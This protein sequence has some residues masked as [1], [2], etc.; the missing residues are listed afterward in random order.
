MRLHSDSAS[1]GLLERESDVSSISSLVAGAASRAGAILLIRGVA[2][3]GKTE[4]LRVAC[5][6]AAERGMGVLSARGT[7]LERH[8]PY[9][10]ARQLADR[11]SRAA[12]QRA[13]R[14]CLKDQQDGQSHRSPT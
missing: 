5:R 6:V 3:V 9:G 13:G 2:G 14:W 10:L 12:T 11:P 4:L 1:L 7:E 8:V